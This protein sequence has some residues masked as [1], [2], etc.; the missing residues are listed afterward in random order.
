VPVIILG[1]FSI[2]LAEV[3]YFLQRRATPWARL[4]RIR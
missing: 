1:L 2:V 3:V 4:E